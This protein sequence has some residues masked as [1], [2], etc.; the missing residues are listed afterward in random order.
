M[1]LFFTAPL[2]ILWTVKCILRCLEGPTEAEGFKQAGSFFLLTP[3]SHRASCWGIRHRAA[4]RSFT[5]FLKDTYAGQ[6]IASERVW[7]QFFLDG[8]A[9]LP[10]SR[11][12]TAAQR[13]QMTAELS[14]AKARPWFEPY[15]LPRRRGG[16]GGGATCLLRPQREDILTR[17]QSNI[18][19]IL[20][21]H[22]FSFLNRCRLVL[23][24]D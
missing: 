8:V 3:E 9:P 14:A 6:M 18:F 16:G 24:Q 15:L 19:F 17:R 23:I 20:C 11:A 10:Q 7:R 1:F 12:E 2:L 21:K 13:H 5:V 22:S 4:G